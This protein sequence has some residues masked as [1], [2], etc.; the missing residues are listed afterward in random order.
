[1]HRL[2]TFADYRVPQILRHKGVMR[3]H[4]RVSSMVDNYVE[5]K[6][7]SYEEVSIRAA[8]VV[9]VQQLVQVL[10]EKHE[11]QSK[12][13]LQD[14]GKHDDPSSISPT[15]TDVTVDWFLWQVGEKLNNEGIMKPF[16]RTRTQFY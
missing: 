9:A 15:F 14:G 7:S 11:A 5:L 1:M 3:Y 16:H 8:T 10:N 6:P 12:L 4:A 13:V 2:T